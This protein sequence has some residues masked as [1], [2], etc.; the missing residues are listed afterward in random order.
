MQ[1][2]YKFGCGACGDRT[3]NKWW[4]L[5]LKCKDA[6]KDPDK[7]GLTTAMTL[8]Q[9]KANEIRDQEN[10]LLGLDGDSKGKDCKRFLL[11]NEP[12]SDEESEPP[13]ENGSNKRAKL[14]NGKK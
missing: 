10:P 12:N 7:N 11:E 9:T 13:V 1:S 4:S 2:L 6:A 3:R 8:L 14:F 5:C